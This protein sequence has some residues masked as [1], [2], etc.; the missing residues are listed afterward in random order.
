MK[1]DYDKELHLLRSR[2]LELKKNQLKEEA[3][4][5]YYENILPVVVEKFKDDYAKQAN[6]CKYLISMVGMSPEPIILV[7]QTLQPQEVLF[8]YTP[9]T[10]KH[11]D[12]IVEYLKLRASGFQKSCISGSKTEEVYQE[13]KKF[14]ENRDP[15]DCFIDISGGKKS[16]VG[17]AAE[18]A[19]IL[20]TRVVYVDNSEYSDEFR[21]PL[22]GSEFLNFLQ[23]P[24]EVFGE[25]DIQEALKLYQVG[26]YGEALSIL[27]RLKKK[28]AEIQKIDLLM[29]IIS[30]HTLWEEHQFEKAY[31]QVQ[32]CLKLISQYRMGE[33][34]RLEVE[35]KGELLNKLL[36]KSEKR[37]YLVFHHYFLAH[38]YFDRKKFDFAVLMLYR[39]IELVLSVHLYQKY[40]IDTNNANLDVTHPLLLARYNNLLEEAYHV[41][42]VKL[43]KLPQK[44][45]FMNS[46]II[47]RALKDPL[48]EGY[49]LREIRERSDLR[50]QSV[51]AHGLEPS[52]S[53]HFEQ[54]N[55]FFTPI[56]L[57]F[58]EVYLPEIDYNELKNW[59][60]PIPLTKI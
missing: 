36:D 44:L 27:S 17:G 15:T 25:L 41:R 11:L 34:F 18:A 48:V 52:T 40:K 10:S 3:R 13:I 16:M 43:D 19:G 39:T 14:M 31:S 53:H 42:A 50:N 55:Q 28:I 32:N 59:Y 38:R 56:L 9:D 51:L 26:S 5:L 46:V 45:A 33:Q 4:K 1:K 2:W 30:F 49:N 29:A 12:S 47:L 54:M 60:E 22:P 23:N 35:R 24:Y 37:I 6:Q 21:Q 20:G 7:I 58:K 57:R 8:L